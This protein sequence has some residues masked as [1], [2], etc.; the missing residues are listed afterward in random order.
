M[1]LP[2][3]TLKLPADMPPVAMTRTLPDHLLHPRS[4]HMLPLVPNRLDSLE[5][6]DTHII[7][8]QRRL[9][10]GMP[11]QCTRKTRLWGELPQVDN[12][13]SSLKATPGS[14]HSS[15]SMPK[16]NL[17]SHSKIAFTLTQGDVGYG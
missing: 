16:H 5:P 17:S 7:R 4:L 14:P 13:A 11:Q 15:H 12:L 2:E 1:W 3:Q 10:L 9:P 8:C 6:R